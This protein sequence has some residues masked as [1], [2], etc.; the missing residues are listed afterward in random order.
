[1]YKDKDG[2][3]AYV[4]R[5]YSGDKKYTDALMKLVKE[6]YGELR[7]LGDE[8][9]MFP[10][11]WEIPLRKYQGKQYIPLPYTDNIYL[12]RNNHSTMLFALNKEKGTVFVS[13]SPKVKL[14]DE[15]KNK[16]LLLDT[17]TQ[18]GYIWDTQFNEYTQCKVCNAPLRLSNGAHLKY[19][20]YVY[21]C[22]KCAY[23]DGL[24]EAKTGTGFAS[25][26]RKDTKGLWKDTFFSKQYG[27]RAYAWDTRYYTNREAALRHN[28]KPMLSLEQAKNL[29]SESLKTLID[30]CELTTY[31][32]YYFILP[33]LINKR[34]KRPWYVQIVVDGSLVSNGASLKRLD[35]AFFAKCVLDKN[36]DAYLLPLKEDTENGQKDTPDGAQSV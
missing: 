36:H 23:D 8:G 24:I 34:T 6:R 12:D 4:G 5:I 17:R 28:A 7:I 33:K 10:S 26:Q 11:D 1:M 21:C 35:P 13:N 9:Y 20:D 3:I 29:T 18:C 19:D 25:L 15:Y 30:T 2:K 14:P 32:S 31:T 22:R 27:P 16:K